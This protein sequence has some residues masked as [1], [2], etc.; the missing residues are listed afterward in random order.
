VIPEAVFG[1]G[2]RDVVEIGDPAEFGEGQR[3]VQPAVLLEGPAQ[4]AVGEHSPVAP[5]PAAG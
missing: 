5:A 3:A 1:D 4:T 2:V